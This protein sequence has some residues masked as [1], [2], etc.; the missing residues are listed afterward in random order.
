MLVPGGVV[1][2]VGL[3]L[4]GIRPAGLRPACDSTVLSISAAITSVIA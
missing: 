2:V 1:L 4:V 3:A